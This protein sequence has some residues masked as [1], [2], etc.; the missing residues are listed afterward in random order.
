VSVPLNFGIDPAHAFVEDLWVNAWVPTKMTGGT[1]DF[2]AFTRTVHECDSTRLVHPYTVVF[3]LPSISPDPVHNESVLVELA[4]KP[5]DENVLVIK[6]DVDRRPM[7]LM[8]D[9]IK[10]ATDV[11][12]W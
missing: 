1:M 11:A 5:M 9:D 8:K 7:N 12:V 10:E 4:R 3:C 6:H 2:R